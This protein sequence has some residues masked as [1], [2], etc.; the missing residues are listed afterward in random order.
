M[1]DDNNNKV[2]HPIDVGTEMDTD[3]LLWHLGF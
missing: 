2:L 3:D 1:K